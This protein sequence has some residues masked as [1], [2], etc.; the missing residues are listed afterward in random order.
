[1]PQENSNSSFGGLFGEG[2]L[3]TNQACNY[4]GKELDRKHGLDWY[5]YGTRN[6]DTALPV[7]TTVDPLAENYYFCS[8]YHYATNNPIIVIDPRAW[9]G[10]EVLMV[11][12][13]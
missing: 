7:W 3:N 6:Y 8:P 1:M 9:T 11:Q 12:Q 2:A 13:R 4:N 10:T 5:D